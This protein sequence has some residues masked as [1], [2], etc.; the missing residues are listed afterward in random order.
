MLGFSLGELDQGRHRIVRINIDV[1]ICMKLTLA[2]IPVNYLQ[3][4]TANHCSQEGCRAAP[5]LPTH[6]KVARTGATTA[7]REQRT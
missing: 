7:P 3:N 1:T 5:P 6:H 4:Q 2:L